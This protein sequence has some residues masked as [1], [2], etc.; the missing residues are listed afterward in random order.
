MA[1]K[2]RLVSCRQWLAV[3]A[4]AGSVMAVPASVLGRNGAVPP[5]D[6][7]VLAGIGIGGRGAADLASFL[8]EPEVQF[9]AVCEVREERREAVKSMA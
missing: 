8:S 2:T 6:R 7:I 9:V 1:A 3:A 5:S 4:R